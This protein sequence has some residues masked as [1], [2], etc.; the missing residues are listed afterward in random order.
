M[1]KGYWITLYHAVSD[2]ARLAKYAALAGPAIE[3]GGG[4]ILARGVAA[5]TFEGRDNQRTVV[6]EFDSVQQAVAAYQSTSY[7]TAANILKGAVDREVRIVEG[8]S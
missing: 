7:Q 3:A 4:R 6:I 8:L 2:P 5:E 1:P